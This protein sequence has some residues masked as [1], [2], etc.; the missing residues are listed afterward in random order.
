MCPVKI[1]AH[2]G[3]GSCEVGAALWGSAGQAG[4][5]EARAGEEAAVCRWKSFSFRVMTKTD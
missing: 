3:T 2:P 4:R 1:N 5:L